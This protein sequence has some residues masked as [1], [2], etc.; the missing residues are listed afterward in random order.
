V[1]TLSEQ[2]PLGHT[3]LHDPQWFGSVASFTQEL[4]QF[5]RPVA[6]LAEHAPALQTYPLEEAQF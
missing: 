2:A 5:V 1:H 3:V 4:L 6:Q